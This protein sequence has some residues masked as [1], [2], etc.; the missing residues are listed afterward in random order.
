MFE[1][2]ETND[3]TWIHEKI[4]IAGQTTVLKYGE[5]P[6]LA[7]KDVKLQMSQKEDPT[8]YF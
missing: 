7:N 6:V 3:F 4:S 8:R 2:L 1:K 5:R